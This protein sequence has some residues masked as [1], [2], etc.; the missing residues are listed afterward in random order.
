MVNINTPKLYNGFTI[1]ELLVTIAITALIITLANYNSNWVVM[2]NLS[3]AKALTEQAVSKTRSVSLMNPSGISDT[4]PS[5][6][7][8][9]TTDSSTHIATLKVRQ[10]STSS[11]NTAVCSDSNSTL[12]WQTQFPTNSY[13]NTDSTT[14]FACLAFNNRG[15][16]ITSSNGDSSCLSPEALPTGCPN[17]TS[18]STVLPTALLVYYSDTTPPTFRSDSLCVSANLN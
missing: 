10:L 4:T 1:V 11:T 5:A 15:Q 13:A 16:Y 8:C 14:S 7:L 18:S 6:S 2:A 12:I 17:T 3:Q 9:L